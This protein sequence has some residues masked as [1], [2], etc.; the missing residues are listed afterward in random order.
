MR[1]GSSTTTVE[2]TTAAAA[3]ETEDANLTANFNTR[4]VELL[5]NPG[6]DL[7]AVALTAPGAVM[8]TAG[9]A[10]FGGGN[11]EVNG[12][13]ATSNL[14]TIDGSN[15]NDPYFNVNNSG[16]TNLT[17]GL[18]DI[19]E[20]TVVSNGYSGSYGG[21]AGANVNYVTKSGTNNF[22]GNAI[23]WWNGDILNANDY[24]RNQQNAL[25]G[26]QVAPRTFVNDNQFAGSIGGPIKKDKAFFFFDVEGLQLAIPSPQTL[27]VP[28][29]A[30]QSAVLANLAS[31]A[32]GLSQSVPF[33][34]NIFGLYNKV[35]QAGAKQ[36]G[37]GVDPA[38]ITSKNPNGTPTGGGCSDISP[39]TEPAFAAFASA[40]CAVQVQAALSAHSHDRLYVGKY[41]MNIGNN[42]KLFVRVEREHG[43]QATYTDGIDPAFNVISDQP[44]WQTQVGETHTFG[45]DQ[46]E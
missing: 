5:P 18:N 41:D 3:I 44:Q 19:S 37:A 10:M 1:L 36:L 31:P 16:A 21:L 7:S 24:F 17:L 8:N 42:D 23:Y 22:H 13:P 38:T 32:L 14:F 9:G 28:T 27:K 15:D 30:F 6:N 45:S 33:Y 40:P 20:S 43:L 39:S 26:S 2:V 29:P 12:L 46:G 35:S 34:Q 11:F 25:A 4:Q